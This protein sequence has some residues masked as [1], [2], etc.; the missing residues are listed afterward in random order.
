VKGALAFQ[1]NDD[2]L[3]TP[4]VYF[5]RTHQDDA[6]RFYAA[7]S[8]ASRG[9][10][11]N[12]PLVP[13]AWTD[14][15]FLPSIKLEEHLSFAELTATV[16]YLNRD[17]SEILDQ[18]VFVCPSLVTNG[19]PGCGNPLG[20][21]YP[22]SA[23]QVAYTPTGLTV[24]ASTAEVRLASNTPGARLTWVAGLFYDHRIQGDFQ[25]SFDQA[26]PSANRL[27]DGLFQD[28]HETFTDDQIAAYAQADYHVTDKL[29][30]TLGERIA[31]VK[32]KVEEATLASLAALY[33]GIP[34]A[35]TSSKETVSTPREALSFQ[36]DRDDLFFVSTSKGFRIGGGNAQ[37]PGYC[38][39]VVPPTYKSDY[40][41]NYELGAKNTFLDG[42]LEVNS[43]VYHSVW[44]NIQQYVGLP[45][46]PFAYSTNAG[47][48]V[49]NGLDLS[50]RAI[51]TEQLRVNLNVG[52]VDAY[53]NENANDLAG[54]PLVH[55]N[56]KVG[57]LPQVN[58]PWTVNTIV[59]YEI[60]LRPGEK[61]DLRGEY[62][63]TSRN[64]G[65]FITQQ[66]GSQNTYPLAVPDPP[67]HLYNARVAYAVKGVDVSMFV[68]N[69]FNNTP[70]LSKYQG[71][72]SSNWVSYTTFRPRTIGV[73]VSVVF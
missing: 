38:N 39:F 9:I 41:Q 60:P 16:S 27:A 66:V 72:A 3:I 11:H 12:G 17:V 46:G 4:S 40:V 67:T 45:C 61:L 56:D 48:A 13:E 34:D 28:Q 10:F 44:K 31:D 65:P 33:G 1:V 58:P 32:V 71:V 53:Y 19:Q 35:T 55:K 43:T 5:Q 52:Y 68:N 36:A 63:Y 64:P 49:S 7:F 50:L 37:V 42:K 26:V 18:G 29:S 54:N 25:S 51:V 47:S 59:N 57:I 8:D 23:S 14:H 21:G 69:V 22:S 24:K 70:A 20:V 15:W 6:Q 73:S 62:N 30:A 2:V